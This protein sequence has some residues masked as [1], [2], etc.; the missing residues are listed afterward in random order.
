V[1][2]ITLYTT[3]GCHLCELAHQQLRQLNSDQFTVHTIDIALDDALVK[4]YGTMIPVIALP[5]QTT[6]AWP[7]E[8]HDI[9]ALL[10]PTLLKG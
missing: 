8:F 2:Q 10:N 9:E 1:I 4:Q 5:D 6:L 7:F 3:V